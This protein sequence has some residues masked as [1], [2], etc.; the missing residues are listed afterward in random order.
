ME[1]LSPNRKPSSN[2]SWSHNNEG[3]I[4]ETTADHMLPSPVKTSQNDPGRTPAVDHWEDRPEAH[5]PTS[6]SSNDLPPPGPLHDIYIKSY[7]KKQAVKNMFDHS[8]KA[9]S[10]D[11]Q[12]PLCI[13]RN[14]RECSSSSS[15]ESD[16]ESE[17]SLRSARRRLA[18]AKKKL[19]IKRNLSDSESY[20]YSSV[21]TVEDKA[22]FLQHLVEQSTAS[23]KK[24]SRKIRINRSVPKELEQLQQVINRPRRAREREV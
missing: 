9:T 4:N 15:E 12:P 3:T 24:I 5:S 21:S 19:S 22:T 6:I 7:K 17:R 14:E 1:A 2:T 16:S 20:E 13:D 11:D 23:A 18:L 8:D 10:D